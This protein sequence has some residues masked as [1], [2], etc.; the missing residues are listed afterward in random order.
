MSVIITTADSIKA[1]VIVRSLGRKGI[2]ITSGD[3]RKFALASL[4]KYST[5]SFIYPSPLSEP[6]AFISSLVHFVKYNKHDVL[7]STHSEDTHL[8]AKHKSDLEPYVKVPLHDYSQLIK[9]HDKGY[10][11][12]VAQELGMPIPK[13]SFI[14]DLDELYRVMEEISFPAVVKLRT[15]TSS[16]GI[17]FA[18]TREELITRF[19]ATVSHFNLAPEDYP[20]V[21]EYIPGDG[22]GVSLLFNH[23]ELRARFT[24]RRI[25][26]YPPSGGPSSYRISTEHPEMEE[27][28][29][30]LLKYFH[31]HGVAMVEFKLNNR[32]NKPVLLEVNP[33]FW[34]SLNQAICCN[35]DFPYLLYRMAVDGDVK[36]V[37]TYKFGVKTRVLFIDYVTLLKQLHSSSHRLSTFKEFFHSYPD[38]IISFTDLLPTLG[39]LYGQLRSRLGST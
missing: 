11:M 26:E 3:K 32:N 7:I 25:R 33:R 34:G 31:W 15:G 19:K 28:A 36:P 16:T 39:F 4:S 30:K 12:Q 21:Q 14:R 38:D 1:L 2:K 24:H 17:S 10:I 5:G 9:A 37:L 20:L 35:V 13:T 23:G 6:E 27:I 8:I 18:H 29:I 22:Y